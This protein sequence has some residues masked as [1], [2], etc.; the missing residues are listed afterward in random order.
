MD[1]HSEILFSKICQQEG[2]FA[3]KIPTD[4][5]PS[6]DFRVSTP[7]GELIAE[8]KELTPNKEERELIRQQAKGIIVAFGDT[9]GSR[10]RGEIQRACRQ[11]KRFREERLPSLVVLYNNVTAT[12][13]M[14]H[15]YSHDI[16]AAM[17]GQWVTYVSLVP[18]G[19]KRPDHNGGKRGLTANNGRYVSAVAVIS[20]HDDET[21]LI[22]H[23]PHAEVP[24]PVGIF[25]G[26]KCIHYRKPSST[27]GAPTTWIP[28]RNFAGWRRD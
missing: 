11:L 16:D 28:F 21:L 10:A 25:T 19:P 18:G 24:L 3:E 22:Y 6:P 2:F 7:Y 17:N 13:P 8:V 9:I 5:K 23:N 15:L 27:Y 1:T 4:G 14:L 20:D 12:V 26:N